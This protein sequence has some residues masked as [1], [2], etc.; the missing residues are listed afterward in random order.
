MP[1]ATQD[2]LKGL[3][4]LCRRRGLPLTIQ[5]RVILEALL[6]RDDHPTVDQVFDAVKE[7]IPGVSRT[8]VYRTL[9][10][11]VTLGMAQKTS[12]FGA[13]ARFDGNT[14]HHHHLVCVRCDTIVD[15]AAPAP[16]SLRLPAP[17][18]AGFEIT[19]FSIYFQGLC[20]DCRRRERMTARPQARARR[21]L[22]AG[23][24]KKED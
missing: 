6:E 17:L 8:T 15:C 10:T 2:A 18:R 12:H 22:L 4:E 5:R 11:L 19:D 24:T 23:S 7:R 20:P 9:E 14:D 1:R 16:R 13:V 21:S 3:E